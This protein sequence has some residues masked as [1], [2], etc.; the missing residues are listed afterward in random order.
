[1]EDLRVGALSALDQTLVVENG[2]ELAVLVG[3]SE[4]LGGHELTLAYLKKRNKAGRNLARIQ[5]DVAA[6]ARTAAASRLLLE[7]AGF[8]FEYREQTFSG[9]S[10]ESDVVTV[11]DQR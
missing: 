6:A 1:V 5:H 3:L 8:A 2:T 11:Q 9:I 7:D 4:P 10:V